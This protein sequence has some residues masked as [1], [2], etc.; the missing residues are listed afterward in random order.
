[1]T[2]TRL[3]RRTLLKAAT[4]GG[5]LAA[6]PMTAFAQGTAWQNWSGNQKVT[7]AGVFYPAGEAE[8]VKVVK[9]AKGPIRA[10]GGGHSFSAVVPT[11]GSL[12]SLEQM[13]GLI[14][15]DPA[16]LQATLGGGTRIAIA[17]ELLAGIG[18]NLE[19]EPDINMQSLAG[20]ISTATHGTGTRLKCLSGY[21]TQLKLV[22]ADGS[23][24]TCSK[25]KDAELF[26]AARVGVGSLGIITEITFQNRAAYKLAETTTVM[27]FNAACEVIDA[28]RD[29]DRHIE[30]FAFAHGGKA[31]VMQMN[32]TDEPDTPPVEEAFDENTLLELAADTVYHAPFAKGVVQKLVGAFVSDTRRVGPAHRIFPNV[33]SVQFNEMEYTVPAE[34]GIACLREVVQVI[35]ERDIGVFFPIEFRYVAA[36]DTT[37]GMFSQRA[38]ASISVHQYHRQDYRE[39]FDA[40]EPVFRKYQGRPHWG[41][42]H[43]LDAKALRALYPRWDEFLAVRR[44]VDPAG[45][46]LN[47]HM[48][49]LFG[50]PA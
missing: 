20:A 36:D 26:D 31:M 14:G 40:V 42:L 12:I 33:R 47:A 6:L 24:V 8:L 7:P 37:L 48:R 43:T 22:L 19:N 25:E 11:P 18:Q 23:V 1:M 30:I 50:L 3:S 32:I 17:G 4:A 46:F 38:G 13:T 21:V 45:R 39:L 15:H 41:K 10:F 49:T 16:R 2:A 9:T 35:R 27:D 29:L 34:Q 28:R 44:R 5:A